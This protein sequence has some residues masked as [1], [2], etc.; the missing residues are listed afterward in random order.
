MKMDGEG[1]AALV[2]ITHGAHEVAG[3]RVR[4]GHSP[5]E[6]GDM[7]GGAHKL[8]ALFPKIVHVSLGR[9]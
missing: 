8:I 4:H 3:K 5:Y 6:S 7:D 9:A 2:Q 1:G